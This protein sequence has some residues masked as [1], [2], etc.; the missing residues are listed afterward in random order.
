MSFYNFIDVNQWCAWHQCDRSIEIETQRE[1][2]I[3]SNGL[4]KL[5]S[6][7]YSIEDESLHSP[8][9][10][11]FSHSPKKKRSFE[12][13]FG[14]HVTCWW[15]CNLLPI[16]SIH[17]TLPIMYFIVWGHFELNPLHNLNPDYIKFEYCL[18]DWFIGLF[19]GYSI[20]NVARDLL[21]LVDNT[22]DNCSSM[23]SSYLINRLFFSSLNI[24]LRLSILGV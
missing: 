8:Q 9:F 20:E 17:I 21:C 5:F 16:A 18:I 12:G 24:A 22:P 10:C 23:Q 4:R 7:S 15:C 2:N 14:M 19:W 1:L 3:E 6:E 11:S 13:L